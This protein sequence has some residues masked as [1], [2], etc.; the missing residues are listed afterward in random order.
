MMQLAMYERNA[1]VIGMFILMLSGCSVFSRSIVTQP[2]SARPAAAAPAPQANGAIFQ[3][4]SYRPMFEDRRARY[5][6]DT[7]VVV[8]AENI[9]ASKTA[10]SQ[11]EKSGSLSASVPTVQG[12]PGKSFQGA[13]VS[14]SSDNKF[15]GKGGSSASNVFTGTIS[16]TVLEVL[17]NGN[18][19]VGGEKQIALA[20]G[21][22]TIRISG[23]VNPISIG[24]GN[25][26]QSSQIADARI[27][28]KGD[29][30]IQEAQTMGWLSRFFLSFLPF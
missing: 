21:T 3:T 7:L 17:P 19:M 14:A 25:T 22:E 10:E 16:V 27:E 30:Y 12:L 13:N 28:Y 2:V 29:G 18:L 9:N 24:T 8:I 6:G 15:D 23:V 4:A 20:Q 11:A 26:V 5:V 1:I